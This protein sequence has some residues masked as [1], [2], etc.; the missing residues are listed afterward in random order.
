MKGFY[1]FR[2]LAIFVLAAAVCLSGCQ[3]KA[4]RIG[5]GASAPAFVLTDINGNPHSLSS[6]RGKVVVL[7]F[8]AT[9]C[10]PCRASIPVLN[11]IYERYNG[12]GVEMLGVSID[13]GQKDIMEFMKSHK[14][15]YTLLWDNKNVAD[16]Y[17][18][19]SIPNVFIIDKNGVI[20]DH[21]LGFSADEFDE[22]SNEIEGLLK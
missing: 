4:S 14:V 12:R 5:V 17:N 10:P 15:L 20:R 6:L 8:W 16:S 19:Q 1:S 3:R 18:V 13:D 7:D 9:W 22:F 2:A 11:R 21:H